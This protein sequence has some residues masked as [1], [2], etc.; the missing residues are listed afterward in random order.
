MSGGGCTI[1]TDGTRAT[2]GYP[3]PCIMLSALCNMAQFLHA[4]RAAHRTQCI[5]LTGIGLACFALCGLCPVLGSGL[6]MLWVRGLSRAVRAHRLPVVRLLGCRAVRSL[7]Y[8]V[9]H[10][11]WHGLRAVLRVARCAAL[12]TRVNAQYATRCFLRVI[13]QCFRFRSAFSRAPMLRNWVTCGYT[14][15]AEH[16]WELLRISSQLARFFVYNT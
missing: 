14:R 15:V 1:G 2:G 11:C 5:M 12:Y 3:P 13:H 6:P 7:G 8:C 4:P 9:V 16:L 10:Q